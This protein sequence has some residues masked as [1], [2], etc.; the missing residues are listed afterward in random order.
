MTT[1]HRKMDMDETISG[2]GTNKQC[3]LP[4]LVWTRPP[5]VKY[6]PIAKKCPIV[7]VMPCVSCLQH[8]NELCWVRPNLL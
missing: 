2:W 7:H 6:Y 4:M 8:A 3:N 1:Q 5:P